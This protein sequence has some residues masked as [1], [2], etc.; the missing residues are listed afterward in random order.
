MFELLPKGRVSGYDPQRGITTKYTVFLSIE[1]RKDL[2]VTPY[3]VDRAVVKSNKTDPHD[4]W[5]VGT[6]TT[7]G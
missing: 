1:R 4:S 5:Q 7:Q 6:L 2:D 3:P